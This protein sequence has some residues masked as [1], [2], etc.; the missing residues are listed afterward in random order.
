[1]RTA[2]TGAIHHRKMCKNKFEAVTLL[3]KD[4]E[5]SICHVF[6]QHA[7]CAEYFCKRKEEENLFVYLESV[8]KM[9]D[10]IMLAVRY[11]ASNSR[12]LIEDIDSNVWSNLILLYRHIC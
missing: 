9:Y 10:K 3:Q 4:I 7:N 11:L 8:G 5:N 1:M 6:S 12:S 2:V